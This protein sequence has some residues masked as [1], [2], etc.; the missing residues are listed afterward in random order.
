ML[1]KKI[2]NIYVFIHISAVHV[3]TGVCLYMDATLLAFRTFAP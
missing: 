1:F 2:K 3:C